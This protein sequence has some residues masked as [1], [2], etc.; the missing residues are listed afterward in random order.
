[1]PDHLA[2][3]GFDIQSNDALGELVM[4]LAQVSRREE[5]AGGT[6]LHWEDDSGAAFAMFVDERGS[7]VCGKPTFRRGPNIAARPTVAIADPRGCPF[8][9]IENVE[10]LQLGEMAYP[11]AIELD[12][13]HLGPIDAASARPEMHATAFAETLTVYA[14]ES[15][16]ADHR[17][18]EDLQMATKSLIPTGL[19]TG[20][21]S[22]VT[23]RARFTGFVQ[24]AATPTNSFTGIAFRTARV[25]TFAMTIDVV[26]PLSADAMAPGNVVQG[27]FW[28]VG[29]RPQ[30]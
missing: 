1:M 27:D 12:D 9:G 10:V 8:C 28:I 24:S 29:S 18:T 25:E 19:F 13:W 3:V 17:A 14:D 23:A 6:R 21:S 15:G 26:A 4:G 7:I 20:G 22:P 11:L 16:F 5:G 2:C 30:S